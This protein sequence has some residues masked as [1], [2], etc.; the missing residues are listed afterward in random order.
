MQLTGGDGAAG[1]A[2]RALLA[3]LRR[4]LGA[5]APVAW[6]L[7][8]PSGATT[9]F[10]DGTPS[11]TLTLRDAA[12]LAA[13]RSLDELR[14]C[15]AYMDEHLDLDG[16]LRA[17][18]KLR[19][20]LADGNRWVTLWRRLE[21][22]LR[23]RERAHARWVENHY[24]ADD[25]QLEFVDTAYHAYTPGVFADAAE[26]LEVASERKLRL[27]F[28]GVGLRSGERVLDVGFGWG[29]F[30]RY[31]GRRG[32]HVTGLTLSRNQL[33]YVQREVV[34]REQLPATLLLS[35]FF[36]HRPEATYDAVV[37]CGALEELGDYA[38]VMQR[39]AAWLKPGGRA[40]LDFMAAR[41]DFVLPAFISKHV[42]QGA[43][44]RVHLPRL[45]EAVLGSPLELRALHDDRRNY[46]LTSNHW[47]ERYEQN[48]DAI[49]A[50]HGERRFRLFRLYLAGNPVMLADPSYF[51]GAYRMFLE[52]P[53]DGS[54]VARRQAALRGPASTTG[55]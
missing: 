7:R 12:G 39:L 31:A 4:A 3:V 23:G 33:A 55:S 52:L 29:P 6:Q 27:A 50:R 18:V 22:L 38:Q 9:T 15:E 14:L 24:D 37:V 47:Y 34:E 32:V 20:G 40:Y 2:E 30:V 16:D 1:A 26:A 5:G 11:F 36:A 48:R 45:V 21:P 8:L 25:I 17:A 13:L 41:A 43:T 49:R 46:Y 42:F 54:H 51:A 35:D 28:E 44:S 53:A 19:G 10:G